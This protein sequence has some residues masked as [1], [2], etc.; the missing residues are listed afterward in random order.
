MSPLRVLLASLLAAAANLLLAI[1]AVS[2]KGWLHPMASWAEVRALLSFGSR[3]HAGT[4]ASILA[5]RLDLVTLAA[6][7]PAAELG[8]YAIGAAA[9]SALT[10]LPFSASL[11]VYPAVVQMHRDAVR[12]VLARCVALVLPFAVPV[13][14]GPGYDAAVPIGQILTFG[15]T[16]RGSTALLSTILRGLSQPLAAGFGDL[17]ALPVLTVALLVMVPSWRGVGA[18]IALSIAALIGFVVILGLCMRSVGMNWL[19]VGGMWQR[20]G[21][22][23][24]YLIR[25]RETVPVR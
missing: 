6:L 19:D 5:S 1:I 21:A 15:I 12:V 8:N 22:R 13:V 17:A 2:R 11:A 9:G 20:D 16:I 25:R 14:F 4:V 18:A 23:A 10:L 3:V 24:R 7:V